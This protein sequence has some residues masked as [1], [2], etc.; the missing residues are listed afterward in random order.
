MVGSPGALDPLPFPSASKAAVSNALPR[1][2]MRGR[3]PQTRCQLVLGGAAADPEEDGKQRPSQPQ[4][5][6][7]G[8]G[9]AELSRVLGSGRSLLDGWRSGVVGF[10]DG[11]PAVVVRRGRL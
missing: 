11:D 2:T 10:A 8:A 3:T 4:P 6:R 1:D 5:T 7:G 9:A